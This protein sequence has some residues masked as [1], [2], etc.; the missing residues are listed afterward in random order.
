MR[1]RRC[2]TADQTEFNPIMR[3]YKP[4]QWKMSS[5]NRMSYRRFKMLTNAY[6]AFVNSKSA[7]ISHH[8]TI[9]RLCSRYFTARLQFQYFLTFRVIFIGSLAVSLSIIYNYQSVMLSVFTSQLSSSIWRVL[10]AAFYHLKNWLKAVK[11]FLHHLHISVYKI[12]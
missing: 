11:I 1:L 7:D 9:F 6:L 5:L 8:F 2:W 3:E 10:W 12:Q 4:T